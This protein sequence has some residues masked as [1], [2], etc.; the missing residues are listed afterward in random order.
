MNKKC[1][2]TVNLTKK[3]IC[4]LDEISKNC[5]FTGG[6]KLCRT[7]ILRALLSA[8]KKLD[9]D[10]SRVKSQEELKERILAGFKQSC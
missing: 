3:Q 4:F 2:T 9:I 5:R 6:R 10:V 7:S 1:W 8:A